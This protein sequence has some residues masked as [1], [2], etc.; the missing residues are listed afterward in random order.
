MTV[1]IALSGAYPIATLSHFV[2]L[3]LIVSFICCRIQPTANDSS[4]E[5]HMFSRSFFFDLLSSLNK[6]TI[7][8]PS[9]KS[10]T[11]MGSVPCLL[12]L[13]NLS[14][15]PNS[16]Y[17]LIYTI[18]NPSDTMPQPPGTG[19]T[20][21][22]PGK[23]ISVYAKMGKCYVVNGCCRK[24]QVVCQNPL[25]EGWIHLNREPCIICEGRAE[26]SF[27]NLVAV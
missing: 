6:A 5:R 10:S 4:R 18:S 11:I 2:S 15:P 19:T 26:V 12:P 14:F 21:H 13:S 23:K 22:C 3:V 9:S 8:F 16:S 1:Q 17:L 24:H 7:L 27:H 25:C 20:H